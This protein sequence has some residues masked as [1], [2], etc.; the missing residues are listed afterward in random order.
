MFELERV[1]NSLWTL[2][3][4]KIIGL[5]TETLKETM[6][7]LREIYPEK[8][9]KQLEELTKDFLESIKKITNK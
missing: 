2:D 6:E 8:T 4:K 3:T 5:K 9:D 1:L 7:W